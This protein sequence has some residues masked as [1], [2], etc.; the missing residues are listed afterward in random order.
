MSELS[1]PEQFRVLTGC[2]LSRGSTFEPLRRRVLGKVLAEVA[3][4][5]RI[6]RKVQE[7]WQQQP[8]N[9]EEPQQDE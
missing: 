6:R 4:W 8:P 7:A 3:A 1:R 9:V 5:I 2:G